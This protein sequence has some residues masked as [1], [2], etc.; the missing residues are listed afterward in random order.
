MKTNN[1]I[2]FCYYHS[3]LWSLKSFPYQYFIV[4]PC[5]S[6]NKNFKL[7]HIFGHTSDISV[8][9]WIQE[10]SEIPRISWKRYLQIQPVLYKRYFRCNNCFLLLVYTINLS[11]STDLV[12]PPP[13]EPFIWSTR[14]LYMI[15]QKSENITP[16]KGIKVECTD[17]TYTDIF[18]LCFIFICM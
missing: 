13:I 14:Y 17:N 18:I 2:V 9:P 10:S 5:Q 12:D 11:L 15:D 6:F 16:I 1:T 8:F 4:R 7:L 3:S